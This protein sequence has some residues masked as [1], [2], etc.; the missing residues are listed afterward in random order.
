MTAVLTPNF[1]IFFVMTLPVVLLVE[2]VTFRVVNVIFKGYLDEMEQEEERISEY[3]DLGHLALLERNYEAFDGFQEMAS[4]LYWKHFFRKL[5][6][7][8]STFFLLLS[9]HMVGANFLLNDFV[10]APFSAVF[11][12]AIMYFMAKTI[13]YYITD[14][15]EARKAAKNSQ[16]KV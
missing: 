11:A 3:T 7:G 1:L 14:V 6:M 8:S 13:Y 10:Y 12:I 15:N 5:V 9:P 2:R 16:F 4:E